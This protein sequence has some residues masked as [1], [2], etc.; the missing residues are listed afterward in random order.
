MV[1]VPYSFLW[2]MPFIMVGYITLTQWAKSRLIRRFG[3]N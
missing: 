3:L 1:A 2:F